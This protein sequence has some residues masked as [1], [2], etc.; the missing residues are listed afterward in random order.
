MKLLIQIPC[1]NEEQNLLQV[2]ESLP[3]KLEGVDSISIQLVDDA[4]TDQSRE[5]ALDF[6]V[7]YILESTVANNKNLGLVFQRGQKNA[8]ENDFDILVNIDADN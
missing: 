2:L 6:G 4:S 5:I 8:I 1:F 3:K 7:D